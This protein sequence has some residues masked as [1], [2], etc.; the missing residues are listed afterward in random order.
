MN[1]MLG[2]DIG[3]STTKI[4]GL[5]GNELVGVKQVRAS[6]PLTSIYGAIGNFLSEKNINLNEVSRIAITGVG[7]S[8]IYEESIYGIETVK[9]NEFQAIGHGA[10]FVTGLD[11]ILIV[12]MGTGT[13]F[14]KADLDNIARIGG[15]GVGGGTILGLSA[16]MIEKN[17]IDAI[18]AL[19]LKGNLNNVDLMV[20][21]I[22]GERVASLPSDLTAANFGNIK[23]TANNE[24]IALGI[25]NMVFEVI[26]MYAVFALRNETI[27]DVVLTGTLATFPQASSVFS[28]FTDMT[29]L[30]FVIPQN[31]VF[32]TSL[33]ACFFNA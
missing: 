32:A 6:D 15:T 22:I 2:I 27:K 14:V 31:A 11:N 17:D 16:Q 26:G 18:I 23:S 4:I 9:I 13:A 1:T 29:G 8:F 3:G 30:N 20:S 28:R 25:I 5:K 21:D 7:S 12:S 10:R 24:D 19:A 33:G